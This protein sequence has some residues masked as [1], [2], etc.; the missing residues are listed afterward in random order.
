MRRDR[1]SVLHSRRTLDLLR[2]KEAAM[3]HHKAA[4]VLL[5][6]LSLQT[7]Y[8]QSEGSAAARHQQRFVRLLRRAAAVVVACLLHR[9][10]L[11]SS[12]RSPLPPLD[13]GRTV[14]RRGLCL[15]LRLT[16]TLRS[17]P[18][19]K[20]YRVLQGVCHTSSQPRKGHR[21]RR[22]RRDRP[23]SR[24]AQCLCLTR[25]NTIRIKGRDH[26]SGTFRATGC[27]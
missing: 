22:C 4:W 2:N 3:S 7:R 12:H 27:L 17:I 24:L 9:V 26:K 25:S 11:M 6:L 23:D 21:G 18:Q 19:V 14:S 15:E 20:V 13:Q 8:R 16:S 10:C 1:G 5:V